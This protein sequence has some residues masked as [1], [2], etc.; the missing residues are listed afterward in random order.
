MT[1]TDMKLYDEIRGLIEDINSCGNT[2][3]KLANVETLNPEIKKRLN[4]AIKD[5][6]KVYN[7]VDEL[8]QFV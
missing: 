5:L 4:I 8:I 7:T 3:F 2:M 6:S 1:M